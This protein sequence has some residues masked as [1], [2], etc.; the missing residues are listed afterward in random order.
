MLIGAFNP[1]LTLCPIHTFTPSHL[2]APVTGPDAVYSGLLECPCTDRI[3]RSL[4][5]AGAASARTAGVCPHV[6]DLPADCKTAAAKLAAA[7]PVPSATSKSCGC[8]AT[9]PGTFL[10]GM[11]TGSPKAGWGTLVEAET[12]CCAHA[13]GCGGVTLQ[14]GSY[15]ARAGTTPTPYSMKVF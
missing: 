6:V 4:G 1:M 13:T 12:W 11:A 3:T 2:Q 15:T 14:N 9:H 7:A 10:S 8:G 5:V